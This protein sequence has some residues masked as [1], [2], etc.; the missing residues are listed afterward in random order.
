VRFQRNGAARRLSRLLDRE[1][2]Q[3]KQHERTRDVQR[4]VDEVI[5]KHALT[6]DRVVQRERDIYERPAGN[7]ELP[8]RKQERSQA[9][10]LVD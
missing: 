9:R 5:T 3:T 2:D 8:L 4:D 1:P 6:A 10:P 7:R